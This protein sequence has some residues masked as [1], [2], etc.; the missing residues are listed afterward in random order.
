M[1][2][3]TNYE[4]DPDYIAALQELDKE[5]P[6]ARASPFII[7]VVS[8]IPYSGFIGCGGVGGGSSIITSINYVYD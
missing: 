4:N 6:L 2:D 7:K 8:N 1:I 3:T 5:F